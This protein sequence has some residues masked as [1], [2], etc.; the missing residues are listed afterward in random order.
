MTAYDAIL[1]KPFGCLRSSVK[2]FLEDSFFLVRQVM[3]VFG[4]DTKHSAV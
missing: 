1:G 2:I 3:E 4:S